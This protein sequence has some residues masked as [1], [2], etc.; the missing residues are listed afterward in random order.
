MKWKIFCN[1][2]NLW[3]VNLLFKQVLIKHFQGK[4][5]VL[6]SIMF[7]K[8]SKWEDG[9]ISNGVFNS[10]SVS[11]SLKY[12]TLGHIGWIMDFPC[13]SITYLK[14]YSIF[15]VSL[16]FLDPIDMKGSEE[17]WRMYSYLVEFPT[18]SN[19]LKKV[20]SGIIDETQT[21]TSWHY[22]SKNICWNWWYISTKYL[23]YRHLDIIYPDCPVSTITC[24]LSCYSLSSQ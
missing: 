22:W 8:C 12:R 18:P 23:L 24:P 11:W 3:I 15:S 7:P 16:Q 20:K 21:V 10:V 19:Q 1:K 2:K 17:L 13:Q 6:E 14:N 5:V 4:W 9:Q